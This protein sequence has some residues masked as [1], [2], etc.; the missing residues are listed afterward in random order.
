MEVVTYVSSSW[1][2]DH[3]L[4]LTFEAAEHHKIYK[5]SIALKASF[6]N[7]ITFK[8]IKISPLES[9]Y[10]KYSQVNKEGV[11]GRFE[12][13]TE[14]Y[15]VKEI[16]ASDYPLTLQYQA[17][18]EEYCLFPQDFNFKVALFI[19]NS[20]Y[21]LNRLMSESLLLAMI[22]VFFAGFLTSFTPCIFPMIPLTLAVL[23]PRGQTLNFSTK[24]I[25]SLSYVF[26]IAVTYSVFGLIAASTGQMFGSALGNPWVVLVIGL[27]FTFFGLSMLGFFEIKTPTSLTQSRFYNSSNT[28]I[29]GLAAGVIAG[30][31]V[32]PVL[33][34]ILTYISQSGDLKKGS[35][36]MMSFAFGMGMIFVIL[37]VAGDLMKVLPRSGKWLN[38]IKYVFSLAM[39]GLAIYY[40]KPVFSPTQLVLF[41]AFI[42]FVTS[43]SFLFL[44]EKKFGEKLSKSSRAV[45]TTA[46]ALSVSLFAGSLLFSQKINSSLQASQDSHGWIPLQESEL[47]GFLQNGKPTI[48][49]FYADW[50]LSCKEL[51]AITFSDKSVI[52]KGEQFNRLVLNATQ[53]TEFVDRMKKEHKVLGL[54]TL[55]FFNSKGEKISELT[56]T[57]FEG[58][59]DFLNR[60][61]K[62]LK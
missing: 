22:F 24:L 29:F 4:K 18:S 46:V 9:F 44:Y 52:S 11:K 54:P 19:K 15:S 36:L 40:V 14:V 13:V 43:L 41:I 5:D 42:V 56:L 57:G 2:D 59:G 32:G 35:L 20:S 39:F 10:D 8:N 34:S 26:G 27:F 61:D 62:A 17:C 23:V 55:L 31:C 38:S 53:S 16:K 60:L 1:V 33:L 28:F 50:C 58:P 6:G 12:I 7:D 49:D 37:G 45:F 30:P 51:K 3:T 21:N 25:R 48:I 47:A